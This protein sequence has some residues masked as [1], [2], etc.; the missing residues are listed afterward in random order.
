MWSYPNYSFLCLFY[1]LLVSFFSCFRGDNSEISSSWRK[2]YLWPK[3]HI[4][5]P[6]LGI[7]LI[8]FVVH[9]Y[10]IYG[11]QWDVGWLACRLTR[12]WSISG[13]AWV[14][15]KCHLVNKPSLGQPRSSPQADSM[16]CM[17]ACVHLILTFGLKIKKFPILVFN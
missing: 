16:Y 6:F 17:H 9:Y 11:C 12:P 3:V 10:I 2:W 8:L 1:F 4:L 7:Y 5:N 13:W 15:N 14:T